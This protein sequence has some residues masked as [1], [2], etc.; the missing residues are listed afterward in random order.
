MPK[1]GPPMTFQTCC[2]DRERLQSV[3][4]GVIDDAELTS[5]LDTCPDCQ[6]ALEEMARGDTPLPR[7][8]LAPEPTADETALH[9]VIDELKDSSAESPADE[10]FALDFLTPSDRPGSLGKFGKYE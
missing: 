2:P 8:R 1:K 5:H 4:D 7:P 10:D 3:L 9:R 6:S